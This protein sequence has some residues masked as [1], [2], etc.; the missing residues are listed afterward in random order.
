MKMKFIKKTKWKGYK[1][2]KAYYSKENM[3]KSI[4]EYNLIMKWIK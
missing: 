4:L 2:W 3:Q 1:I